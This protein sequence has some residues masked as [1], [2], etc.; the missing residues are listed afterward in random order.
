MPSLLRMVYDYARFDSGAYKYAIG[1]ATNPSMPDNPTLA[2]MMEP[3]CPGYNRVV[4]DRFSE[5]FPDQHILTDQFARLRSVWADMRNEG[6]A[7]VQITGSFVAVQPTA[8]LPDW[9]LL[10]FA[11]DL[12]GWGPGERLSW[13]MH[14]TSLLSLS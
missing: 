5:L 12:A 8:G 11:P 6:A 10:A 13:Q 3:S 9:E 2:D 7:P 1:L 14:L 4:K